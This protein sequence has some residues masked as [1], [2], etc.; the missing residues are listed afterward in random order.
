MNFGIKIIIAF[1]V[2]IHKYNNIVDLIFVT[3][4][5]SVM[6][7]FLTEYKLNLI[8]SLIFTLTK[9]NFYNKFL[10]RVQSFNN[11]LNFT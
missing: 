7:I 2:K 11:I 3:L 1:K 5:L 8:T 9:F 10:L 4:I 6:Y